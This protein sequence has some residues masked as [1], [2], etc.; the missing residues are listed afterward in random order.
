[1]VLKGLEERERRRVS[2]ELRLEMAP[3]RQ[4][5]E[6]DEEGEAVNRRAHHQLPRRR[7]Q[8]M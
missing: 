5:P 3:R 7:Q 6:A 1:V 4:E 8:S 2:L